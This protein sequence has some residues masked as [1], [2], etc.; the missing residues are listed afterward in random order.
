MSKISS[1][2][3][4]AVYPVIGKRLYEVVVSQKNIVALMTLKLPILFSFMF[5]VHK[6]YKKQNVK[7]QQQHKKQNKKKKK[8]KQ[9]K[10]KKK[11]KNKKQTNKKHVKL[12]NLYK[13]VKI[14]AM[15][16]ENTPI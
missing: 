2:L 3:K 6:G 9:T 7:Q 8:N 4:W 5:L 1:D 16:Y 12:S 11:S 15:H 14:G 10:N 13:K